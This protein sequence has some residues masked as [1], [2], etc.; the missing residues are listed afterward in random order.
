MARSRRPTPRYALLTLLLALAL[1][2]AGAAG[3]ALR[4]DPEA[5]PE[6]A[7][8]AADESGSDPPPEESPAAEEPPPEESPAPEDTAEPTGE[9]ETTPYPFVAAVMK[10]D[11]AE[12]AGALIS[13][14]VSHLLSAPVAANGTGWRRDLIPVLVPR[15]CPPVLTPP[16]RPLLT[17]P[18]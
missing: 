5:P 14:N 13:P 3:R 18:P 4:Q 9:G 15:P 6:D 12:C 11:A 10:G 16:I 7:A 17:V 8:A 2:T 1:C